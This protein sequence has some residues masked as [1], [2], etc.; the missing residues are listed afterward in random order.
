[1]TRQ[2][3]PSASNR[4]NLQQGATTVE[5]AVI[6]VAIILACFVTII[7]LANPNDPVN[8]LLPQTYTKVGNHIGNFEIKNITE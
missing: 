6:I 5:Y 3:E 2:S 8:S 7:Y 1:M 4:R